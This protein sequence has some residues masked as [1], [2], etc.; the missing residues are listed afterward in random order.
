MSSELQAIKQKLEVEGVPA[1]STPS[2]SVVMNEAKKKV[3][4]KNHMEVQQAPAIIVSHYRKPKVEVEAHHEVEEVE[5]P[6]EPQQPEEVEINWNDI[7][8]AN[9]KSL[10]TGRKYK[11]NCVRWLEWL[12]E[13]GY[14]INVKSSLDF[15]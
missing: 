1:K 10:Q 4:K 13:S 15:L 7:F 3:E 11:G 9:G 14:D 6:E 8:K 2:S 5:D 12:K